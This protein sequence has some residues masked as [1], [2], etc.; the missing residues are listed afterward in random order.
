M[1]GLRTFYKV[2][3]NIA[4]TSN[5]VL[6]TIGLKSPI[7]ATVD[8][9]FR[10]SIPSPWAPLAVSNVKCWYQLQACRTG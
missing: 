7:A 8:Q 3:V 5:V 1:I 9:N 4:F 6:T 10:A 2:A